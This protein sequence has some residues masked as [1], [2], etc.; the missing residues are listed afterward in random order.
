M[1]A[2]PN[3]LTI[4]NKAIDAKLLRVGVIGLGV[5]AQH[6]LAYAANANCEV[7][8]LCDIDATK[9]TEFAVIYPNLSI[10]DDAM[11]LLNDPTIDIVSIASY[12]DIH[13]KQIIA[14]L[15]NDKHVFVEKPLC[16][17]AEEVREIK[18]ALKQQ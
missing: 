10:T 3:N 13:A 8:A 16:L 15:K 17:Y 11:D 12:D 18:Q 9:R 4:D 7:I 6:I 2:M 1:D 5:G 14:A